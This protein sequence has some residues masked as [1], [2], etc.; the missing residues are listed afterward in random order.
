MWP[1]DHAAEPANVTMNGNSFQIWN[2]AADQNTDL[3]ILAAPYPYKT[4][5]LNGVIVE[6]R[7]P[8]LL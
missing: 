4:L 6:L 1:P 7:L 8:Q 3:E 5:I 2:Y